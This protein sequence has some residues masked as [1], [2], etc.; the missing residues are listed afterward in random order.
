[1]NQLHKELMKLSWEK[2]INYVRDAGHQIFGDKQRRNNTVAGWNNHVKLFYERSKLAFLLW[3]TNG[4]PREGP[5]A[6][7]MREVRVTFKTPVKNC[8]RE[9]ENMKLEFLLNNLRNSKLDKF[10]KDVKS[11]GQVTDSLPE[12]IDYCVGNE[13]I[14]N[15]WKEKFS[16]TLN[17]VDDSRSKKKFEEAL[18]T[19]RKI[20][21]IL[22]NFPEVKDCIREVS[23]N[24]A[25][26]LDCIHNN[27]TGI[28]L[29]L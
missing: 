14:S 22:V 20:N 23:L 11:I 27:C 7:N 24:K 2:F 26:G 28:I 18:K 10:W 13:N 29:V 16:S 21:I 6:Q 9:E 19:I 3:K 12:R 1:M 17:G 8:L 25:N 5:I 15:F 4:V